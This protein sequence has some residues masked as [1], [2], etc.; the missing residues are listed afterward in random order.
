MID[1]EI[2]VSIVEIYNENLRDLLAKKNAT[3][4]KLRDNGEGETTSD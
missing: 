4:V 3:H 2:G 1:Y